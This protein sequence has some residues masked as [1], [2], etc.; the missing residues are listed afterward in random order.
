MSSML[1]YDHGDHT[2]YEGRGALDGHLD[3]HTALSRTSSR[4]ASTEIIRTIR[5]GEPTTA[6]STFTQLC[7]EQVHALRP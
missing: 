6:T 4:F 5:D 2:D 3:F 1:L 7:G